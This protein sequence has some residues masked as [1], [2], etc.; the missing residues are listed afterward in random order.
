MSTPARALVVK[1]SSLGDI[2][3]P[4]PAVRALKEHLGLQID[5][6]TQSE[7]RDLVGCFSDVDEVLVYP[8]RAAL[9]SA[10]EWITQLRER[11]YDYV[12]DFQGLLK[13]ALVTRLAR[14]RQRIGPT[15]AREGARWAYQA[16]PAAKGNERRHAVDEALDIARHFEAPIFE[17]PTFPVAF[18]AL[19]LS[20]DGPHVGFVSRS[21]W[22][23][24]NIQ[25]ALFEELI[26]LIQERW[27]G[28]AHLLGSPADKTESEQLV[29]SLAAKYTVTNHCGATNLVELGSI[30]QSLDLLVTVDSG[31]MH[32]AAALDVPVLALF[33]PT[34]PRRTGPFGRRI[35]VVQ[36]SDLTC[37]P[38]HSRQCLRKE[39]DHACLYGLSA[40]D[41]FAQLVAHP[42]ISLG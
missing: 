33:G 10:H 3:H 21:R 6:I 5:W 31:P 32:M 15:Y 26:P 24:K 19:N 40:A 30:I 28:T 16:R 12:F 1:L 23:T 20:G 17:H 25:P 4:L 13:S 29:Q 35:H 14:T 36:R 37:V 11:R 7:Y 8:R 41:I 38:C 22:P 34:D 2:F 27:G 18:P 42:I 39:K 9:R